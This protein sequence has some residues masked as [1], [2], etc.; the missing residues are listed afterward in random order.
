[1]QWIFDWSENLRF[2]AGNDVKGCPRNAPG[3]GHCPYSLLGIDSSGSRS[4]V[5]FGKRTGFGK[6]MGVGKRTGVGNAPGRVQR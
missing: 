2:G 6:R 1:M 3:T 5:L 4:R